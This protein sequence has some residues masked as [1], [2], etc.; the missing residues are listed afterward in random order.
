MH[1]FKSTCI[2]NNRE[3]ENDKLWKT[4]L[5]KYKKGQGQ[6]QCVI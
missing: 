6:V 1:Q 5:G 3:N 4:P 2:F